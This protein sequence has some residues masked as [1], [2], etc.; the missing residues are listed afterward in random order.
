MNRLYLP[1]LLQRRQ[2]PRLRVS[3]LKFEPVV[4]NFAGIY[5][6]FAT[7]EGII[8]S[9]TLNIYVIYCIRILILRTDSE[10][11]ENTL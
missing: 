10:Y 9:F 1:G 8:Y 3:W 6:P 5:I 2:Q 7:E 11:I 4:S